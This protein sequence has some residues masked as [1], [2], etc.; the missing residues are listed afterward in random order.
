VTAL[1][2]GGPTS[3][4]AE[5]GDRQQADAVQ[6][7]LDA[8]AYREAARLATQLASARAERFGPD[9]LQTARALDLQLDATIRSAGVASPDVA[10]LAERIVRVKERYLSPDDAEIAVSL[11]NLATVFAER[12]ENPRAI[13]E[14]ERALNITRRTLAA[15]DPRL[16]DSLDVLALPLIQTDKYEEAKHALDESLRIRQRRNKNDEPSI[17]MA[18]TVYLTSLL[19]RFDGDYSR[20]TAALEQSLGIWRRIDPKHPDVAML[21]RIRGDL[22]FLGGNVKAAEQAWGDALERVRGA[23]GPGHPSVPRLLNGLASAAQQSGNLEGARRLREQ[24]L[25][26]AA[27][28]LAPCHPLLSVIPNDLGNLTLYSGHFEESR[29]FYARALATS[30]R[31]VGASHSLTATF[32][33]NAGIL[34]VEMGDLTQAE[35]LHR[36]ALGAWSATLGPEHPYVARALDSLARVMTLKGQHREAETLFERALSIRRRLF[37]SNHPDVAGSLVS[38]ARAKAAANQMPLAI[39]EVREAVAIYGRGGR[40]QEP[41][42]LAVALVLLGDLEARRGHNAQARAHFSRAAALRSEMFGAEHPLTA[43]ATARLA[44]ADFVAGLAESAFSSALE[45]ERIGRDHLRLTIRYLPERQALAYAANR[46]RGL[47]LALSISAGGTAPDPLAAFDSVIRSRA[48]ILD[49]LAAR[50]R[51]AATSDPAV[52]ALVKNVTAARE[53][54]ATVIFRSI[55][56][57]SVARAQ[58]DEARQQKDEAERALAERSADARAESARNRIGIDDIRRALPPDT[59]LVSFVRYDRTVAGMRR[60]GASVP[61]YLAFVMAAGSRTVRLV[62]LGQAA[63]VEKAV[64]TWRRELDGPAVLR[65]PPDSAERTYRLAASRLR[66]LV[67]DPLMPHLGAP[68]QVFIVPDGA[69]NLVSFAALPTRAGYLVD[70]GPVIHLLSAERDL[71]LGEKPVA[72]RGLLAVGGPSYDLAPSSNDSAAAT[73]RSGCS[74]IDGLQFSDLP[75]TRAEV[76]A[77]ARIFPSSE[78]TSSQRENITVL[79]GRDASEGAVV[80]TV[81][82]RRILH[83][84]THG[85]FLGTGCVIWC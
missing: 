23:L 26:V 49:E 34:A 51:S 80:R 8:G 82:G 3:E 72:G 21:L 5:L 31:C 37:G 36:R 11:Q 69:L 4:R 32:V 25:D 68:A 7:A 66:Q 33:H 9:S 17:A 22:H 55:G 19:H 28:A 10:A 59:A 43:E 39:R 81:A 75:G 83:L 58:V 38:L 13:I 67:W 40:P 78:R 47:D 74:S 61:S 1:G 24:A 29:A 70:D 44:S 45:A 84:A 57:R 18:R 27:R 41:D 63:G 12:G 65:G 79:S 15:D 42:Y 77:V 53:K 50:A 64:E 6:R 54:F 85:F 46:P 52:A 60:G 56:G 14:A 35:A 16:A 73:L 20:A 62:P 71:V 30:E 48:V 2:C 76:Q